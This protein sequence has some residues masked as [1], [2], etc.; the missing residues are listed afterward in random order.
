MGAMTLASDPGDS[1]YNRTKG[2]LL[3][4]TAMRP[5]FV[6]HPFVCRALIR[7]YALEPALE[8]QLLDALLL[9]FDITLPKKR[10]LD[11][12]ARET[13]FHLVCERQVQAVEPCLRVRDCRRHL[14]G[15]CDMRHEGRWRER[16][17]VRWDV[18]FYELRERPVDL[19]VLVRDQPEGVAW[20]CARKG[21]L[22]ILALSGEDREGQ[23][24]AEE[25]PM[26]FELFVGGDGTVVIYLA[27]WNGC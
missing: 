19:R 6:L 2:Y 24:R 23:K 17:K 22:A 5:I 18:F 16:G 10:L 26:A 14:R 1:P 21:W 7:D 12:Q 20:F 8:R 9:H 11:I 13:H 3:K 15:E 27:F 4:Q 25:T